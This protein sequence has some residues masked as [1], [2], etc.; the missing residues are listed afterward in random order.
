MPATQG[1]VNSA[2]TLYWCGKKLH[3]LVGST[4]M[5]GKTLC[6]SS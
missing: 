6:A 1:S 2:K 5:L 3:S 4:A